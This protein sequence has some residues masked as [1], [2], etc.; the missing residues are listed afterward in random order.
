MS[1]E[2][3]DFNAARLAR[4]NR[5]IFVAETLMADMPVTEA[6]MSTAMADKPLT[7]QRRAELIKELEQCFRPR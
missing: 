4:L 2:I 5:L 6:D 7:P 1:A 3:I